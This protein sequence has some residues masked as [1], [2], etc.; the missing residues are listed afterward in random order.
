MAGRRAAR[1]DANQPHITSELRR[2]GLSV[3]LIYTVGNGV[4]DILVGA[5]GFN[6]LIEIKVNKK[7]K[8]TEDEQT[9]FSKWEG[10]VD[11]A[12]TVEDVLQ[13]IISH[14]AWVDKK[15]ADELV[16]MLHSELKRRRQS[17]DRS[18]R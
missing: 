11:I 5:A 15:E 10:Q 6:I 17:S 13:T 9:F 16:D 2:L 8:L 3:A 14:L 12:V 18:E 7:A 4:P 1:A